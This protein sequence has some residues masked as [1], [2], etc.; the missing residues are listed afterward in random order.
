MDVE[1][2][3]RKH[4]PRDAQPTVAIIDEYCAEYKDLFKEVRNYECLKYLHLGIISPIK[5][6]SL[7]EIAKVVSINSAQSLHHFLA[8][9]DWSVKK[10]KNRRLNKLKRALKG[11]AITVVVDETGDRK[12]GKKTDYVARLYLGS[13][14]KID[15]GIVSVNAYGVYDNITFPLSVK[16]F[17]PKGTLKEGDKYKTKIEL[18]SEIITELINEGFNIERVL[19]D[20]L[21]G[22]SSE[23]IKKLNEYELAYV[24]A[25]SL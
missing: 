9:S 8:Y 1:L 13:V 12:K 18:A 15:N 7:P 6:K 24:V 21:Y 23:F 25:I 17:K 3:I 19:A 4:L 20:S 22:E 10:L 2:Q 11:K 14:G 16:V 5:R